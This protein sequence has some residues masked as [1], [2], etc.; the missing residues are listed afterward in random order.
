[1]FKPGEAFSFSADVM[2]PDAVATFYM[3][4]EY[5]DAN[6]DAQYSTIAEG[7]APAGKW[8]QLSNPEYTI[9]SDAAEVRIYIETAEGTMDFYVDE[10]IGAPAG[11][12]IEGAG[13]GRIPIRGM[14]TEMGA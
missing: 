11:T 9:P 7:F 5:T 3:K 13:A 2:C 4:L 6:G 1:M 12:V 10:A 8:I 14:W